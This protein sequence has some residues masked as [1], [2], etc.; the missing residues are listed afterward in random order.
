MAVITKSSIENTLVVPLSARFFGFF[1]SMKNGSFAQFKARENECIY[2][3]TNTW[4]YN[5][6]LRTDIT[7]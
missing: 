7:C 5:Q 6:I 3:A 1:R 2:I 4:Q